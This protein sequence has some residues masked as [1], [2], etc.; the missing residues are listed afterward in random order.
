V[1]FSQNHLV[2]L[3]GTGETIADLFGH[4]PADGMILAACEEV[5]VQAAAREHL[6]HTPDPVHSDETG[7]RVDGKLCWTHVSSRETITHLELHD[8]RGS[9]ALAATGIFPRREGRTIHMIRK[10]KY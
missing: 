4:P 1:H 3:E 9:K 5:A 6:I 10:V 7:I 2:P 8:K